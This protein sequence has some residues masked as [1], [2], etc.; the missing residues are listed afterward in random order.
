MK[1]GERAVRSWGQPCFG[2]NGSKILLQGVEV[3]GELQ[4]RAA[5]IRTTER[6]RDGEHT[7]LP[8]VT[9][10]RQQCVSAAAPGSPRNHMA[11]TLRRKLAGGKALSL[12]WQVAAPG[13][14]TSSGTVCT[15]HGGQ[16][17]QPA[18]CKQLAPG[19]MGSPNSGKKYHGD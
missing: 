18:R 13:R 6:G 10:E 19:V 12:L 4:S 11:G 17:K 14:R 1:K 5:K 3:A 8:L 2:R 15:W 7:W 9:K 16:V